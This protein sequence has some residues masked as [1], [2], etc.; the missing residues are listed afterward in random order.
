VG[1]FLR[2]ENRDDCRF[3]GTYYIME[4]LGISIKKYGIYKKG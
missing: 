4:L 1:V 2:A 3:H